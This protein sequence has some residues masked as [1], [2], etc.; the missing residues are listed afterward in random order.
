VGDD[1]PADAVAPGGTVCGLPTGQCDAVDTCNGT[2][3]TCQDRK[4]LNGTPCEDGDVCTFGDTCDGNGTCQPG[5]GDVCAVG[6]VAGGGQ[7]VPNTGGIAT[8]GFIAERQ[9]LGGPTTGHFNYFNHATRL[10]V[11]GPVTLLIVDSP[12]TA[13]FQGSGMCNLTPCTFVVSVEDGGEPG[14]N[15]DKLQVSIVPNSPAE[16]GPPKTAISRGN[17][18]V[19]R[20]PSVGAQSE[21]GVTAAAG[22]ILPPGSSYNGV[23]L[24]GSRFGLGV[25]ID[26]AA[27]AEG[28][29]QTTLIGVSALGLKQLIQ[30]EG[31]AS[32]GSS[33]AAD[34]ATF[35]GKCSVDMG[36]GTLPLPDVPF[37]VVIVTNADGKV[38]VTLT[39][40]TLNLPAATIN[41]G[42]IKIK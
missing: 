24:D 42:S 10:H 36:D 4:A 35:S 38:T 13:T 14:R 19:H 34:A 33:W 6:K 40:G 2:D 37:T 15:R 21:V 41:E 22:G 11:N 17:I 27:A 20:P 7:V 28:Q 5:P 23:L 39:L 31:K 16:V 18:Q 9:T 1:C 26:N 3:T 30:V 29:L 8:F 32:S 12:T 25:T